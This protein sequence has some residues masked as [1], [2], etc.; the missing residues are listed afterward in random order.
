M[1]SGVGKNRTPVP[2]LG[3]D[4]YAFFVEPQNEYQSP[5]GHLEELVADAGRALIGGAVA[6][7]GGSRAVFSPLSGP[8]RAPRAAPSARLPEPDNLMPQWGLVGFEQGPFHDDRETTTVTA[9][10]NDQE[11]VAPRLLA[12]A[13]WW[14]EVIYV[15]GAGGGIRFSSTRAK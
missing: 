12:F 6:A 9:I 15:E 8:L 11:V 5:T 2:E 7:Q 10:P 14:N 3:A 1:I 4:A 13:Q